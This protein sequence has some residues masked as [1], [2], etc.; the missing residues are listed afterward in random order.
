MDINEFSFSQ[1]KLNYYP[2]SIPSEGGI[3]YKERAIKALESSQNFVQDIIS[4]KNPKGLYFFGPVGSGKT[5]LAISIAKELLLKNQ[6]VL[7][8]VV[9]DY[10][11]A[12]RHSYNKDEHS[13]YSERELVGI[14]SKVR[15][16]V[17]DDLGAHNYTQWT[18]NKIY[19]LL[20]YRL[21]HRLPTIITSNLSLAELEKFLGERTCSRIIG[22][23]NI[24][25]L[26]VPKDIRYVQSLN[27]IP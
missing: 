2:S 12:L 8:V 15:V 25:R 7:F 18:I 4:L 13:D 1:F 19:S 27:N 20:N 10:L 26:L 24:F 6:E 22:L 11:D 14:T 3:S 23:C 9:P 16:L 5:F 21:N 17:L